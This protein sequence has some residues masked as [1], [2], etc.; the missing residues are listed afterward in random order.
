MRV[1]PIKDRKIWI[2]YAPWLMKEG[3][4]DSKNHRSCRKYLF[5]IPL[6]LT[7]WD[8]RVKERKRLS[9]CFSTESSSL[10]RIDYLSDYYC[11]WLEVSEKDCSDKNVV[12]RRQLYT[13]RSVQ[14]EDIN[15][16]RNDPIQR[17]PRK[18]YYKGKL[19]RTGFMSSYTLE[20]PS[21]LV[22]TRWSNDKHSKR[23]H[24]GKNYK[25]V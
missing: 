22:H 4:F 25:H 15:S 17:V 5:V 21:P 24:S 16:S 14:D 1:F 23:G 19:I 18:K 12:F 2:R 3:K 8:L 6:C 7:F 20:L 10:N 9:N 13:T 11:R